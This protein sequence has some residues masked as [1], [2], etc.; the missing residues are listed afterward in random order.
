MGIGTIILIVI[1][2]IFFLALLYVILGLIITKEI[3]FSSRRSHQLLYRNE[4]KENSPHE[5][6][7]YPHKKIYIKSKFGYQMAGRYYPVKPKSHKYTI[8]IHGYN[9]CS[10][11]CGKYA[12]IFNDRGINCIAPDTRRIQ[13]TGGKG[14]SFGYYERYDIETWIEEI[15]KMDPKAE[16]GMFGISLGAATCILVAEMRIDLKY[17]IPYCSY[18][19]F[20]DIVMSKGKDLY[21]KL[22]KFFYPAI[23]IGGFITMGARQDLID[24]TASIKKVSC[25]TMILHSQ[26]DDFTPYSQALKLKEAKPDAVFRDFVGPQHARSYATQPVLYTKYINDFLDEIGV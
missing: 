19:S 4:W 8:L 22:I 26:D 1:G 9:N 13:E 18:S 15:Y 23:V 6:I 3:N 14:I 12:K 10:I 16:I 11:T 17:I 24:I 5:L 7:N 25:P 20:K 2:A 21:P